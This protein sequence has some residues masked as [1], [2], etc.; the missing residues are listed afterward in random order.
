MSGVAAAALTPAAANSFRRLI[1]RLRPMFGVV[2][3]GI[4]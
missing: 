3:I 4:R 2:M 1:S